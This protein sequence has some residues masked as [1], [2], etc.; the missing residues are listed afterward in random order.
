ML[1][2]L[3]PHQSASFKPIEIYEYCGH[4]IGLKIKYSCV[5]LC[6]EKFQSI[7]YNF[8]AEELKFQGRKYI[9]SR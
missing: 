2:V 9:K 6:W 4:Q 5:C 1:T 8:I 7:N 3:P